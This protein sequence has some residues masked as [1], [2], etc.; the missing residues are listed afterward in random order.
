M[1]WQSLIKIETFY[2]TDSSASVE[3]KKSMYLKT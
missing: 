2:K 3:L 1:T